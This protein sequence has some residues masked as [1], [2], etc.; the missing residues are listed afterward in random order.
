MTE[1]PFPP[2]QAR[3]T[4]FTSFSNAKGIIFHLRKLTTFRRERERCPS[5][6]TNRTESTTFP[7][8]YRN[9]IHLRLPSVPSLLYFLTRNGT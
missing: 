7:Y 4:E 5:S 2:S 3:C 9:V 6:F 1:F 8:A